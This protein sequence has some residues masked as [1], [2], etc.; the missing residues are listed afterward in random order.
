MS[1]EPIVTGA[2]VRVK[3]PAHLRALAGV[4]REVSVEPEGP[5]TQRTV[6]DAIERAYPML[7]GTMRD[8][9]TFAR[10]PMVRFFALEQD[11]SHESPDTPLP[12]EVVRGDEP[13]WVV[14]AIAGG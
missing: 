13:F 7:R 9:R 1:A 8:Q 14:G 11:L 3:M 6:L 10:R 2:T 12:A 4:G 5:V